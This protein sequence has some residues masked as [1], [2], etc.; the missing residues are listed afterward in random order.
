MMKKFCIKSLFFV[1]PFLALYVF[2][3]MYFSEKGD[4][5]RVG[6]IADRDSDYRDIFTKEFNRP[7]HYANLTEIDRNTKNKYTA[8]VVGDS[9][10]GGGPWSYANYLAEKDS[11][12]ALHFDLTPYKPLKILYGLLNGDLLEKT[13]FDYIILETV[14]KKVVSR[15]KAIDSTFT[16]PNSSL[17]SMVERSRKGE[18]N[19]SEQS[20]IFFSDRILKFSLHNLLYFLKDNAYVSETYRVELK[21]KLFSNEKKELLFS[22]ADWWALKKYN[23]VEVALNVNKVLN[24]LAKKCNEKG[25]KLI[26][27]I[28]PDKLDMYYDYIVDNHRYPRPLFFENLGK[29]PK[30]Y[31]YVDSKQILLEAIKTQKDIYFYDDTHWSPRATQLISQELLEIITSD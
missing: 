11:I 8:L 31:I 30:D 22:D 24:H 17:D 12:T 4:L 23:D 13:T 26:V 29:M 1:I 7:I 9:F 28:G 6:Y 5:L 18:M 25:V 16:I 15:V 20:H 27:L 2:E 21:E 10:S 14:E 19:K 3:K